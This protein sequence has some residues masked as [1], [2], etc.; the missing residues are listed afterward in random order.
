MG[1]EG[2]KL[3]EIPENHVSLEE[4]VLALRASDLALHAEQH[5]H[6]IHVQ[7]QALV[8]H[9]NAQRD[10][11]IALGETQRERERQNEKRFDGVNEFRS[12]LKDQA[13]TFL[14]RTEFEQY[15]RTQ[16]S[17]KA[18]SGTSLRG[19]LQVGLAALGVVITLVV[20][21]ANTFIGK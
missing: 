10:T 19:T 21:A 15:I 13:A 3:A 14:T 5:A 1:V 11:M 7:E 2:D 4:H 6:I 12:Q 17:D 16:S 20:I 18:T 9:D 8:Q